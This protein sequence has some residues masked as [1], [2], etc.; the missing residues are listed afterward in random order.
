MFNKRLVFSLLVIVSITSFLFSGCGNCQAKSMAPPTKSSSLIT[1]VPASGNIE[2]FVV[3][4]C[5]KC[6]FKYK[7]RRGCSLTVKIGDSVYPVEGTKIHELGDPHSNEGL[8]SI[9][10]VGYASGEIK[11]GVF[12]SDSFVLIDSPISKQ[13]GINCTKSCCKASSELKKCGPSCTKTCCATK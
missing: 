6:N 11:K 2:G 8:C 5:G 4:A 10:R 1:Q 7:E 12:Y 13:C 3:T 9:V